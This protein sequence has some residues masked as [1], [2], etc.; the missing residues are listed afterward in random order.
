[1]E[2]KKYKI[3]IITIERNKKRYLSLLEKLKEEGFKEEDV[4]IFIGIDYKKDIIP[5]NALSNWSKFTPKSVL[6]CAASHVLLWKYISEQ[7]IDFALILEDD[8][9]V[10][11][12]E[13]DKYLYDFKNVIDDNTFLNLS[14]SYTIPDVYTGDNDLF[15]NSKLVLSLDTYML[16]PCLCEKLFSF[17]KE[18][19]LSY[20]IDLHLAFVKKDIPM[21]ILH[22]NKKITISNMRYESSMVSSHNKKFF[23]KM[24]SGTETYKELNTPIITYQNIEINSYIIFIFIFFIFLIFFSF[25]LIDYKDNNLTRFIL[26]IL[27]FILGCA[28]YDIL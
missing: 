5:N 27:W 7:D 23:L 6:A 2:N 9:Y 17:Y 13:F 22:F 3:F 18:N 21:K 19:G 1:M 12:E 8:S 20:H 26:Y 14:T 24:L 4:N 25:S 16:T 15:T 11:K 28:I 10:I